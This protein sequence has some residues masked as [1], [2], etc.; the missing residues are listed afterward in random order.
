MTTDQLVIPTVD[1]SAYRAEPTPANAAQRAEAAA[2]LD[3]AC[4]D[5]GFVQI[6]G[7]GIDD[8]IIADFADALDEFFGLDAESKSRY[9]TPAGTNRGYT[10][11][12]SVSLSMSLG[13][14]SENLMNDFNEAFTVGREARDYPLA[15]VPQS[16]YPPNVWPAE[17]PTFRAAV[18]RFS[19]AATAV[20]RVMLWAFAD[21]LGVGRTFFESIIDHSIDTLKM[22]N[23]ALIQLPA[24]MDEHPL[25]MGAHTDF[26]ILTVLW[27]DRVAG[28]QILDKQGAWHDVLP[29]EGALLVNL[30]DAM[31]RWT[32][33][34]WLSTVHRVN[35]PISQGR[36]QRRRS[37][38]LFLDGNYDAVI[39]PIRAFVVDG[40]ETYPP[41]T[42]EENIQAKIAGL[43]LGKIPANAN[44]EASRVLAAQGAPAGQSS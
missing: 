19:D 28:L 6:V 24:E 35:P 29:D 27:A 32:N 40:E 25:G 22:N 36:I 18:S 23:Y 15:D 34:Q 7:H 21:A 31:S 10:P 17:A 37:A 8:A 33:D 9:C 12:K 3:R 4:R 43:Q 16:V 20:S 44:R 26:G 5:V 38:A 11:S 30:G 39:E 14:P 2:R 13:I 42:I 1:I 41:I